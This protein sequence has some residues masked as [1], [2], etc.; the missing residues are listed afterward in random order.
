MIACLLPALLFQEQLFTDWSS[1]PIGEPLLFSERG[2]TCGY[3]RN[4]FGVLLSESGVKAKTVRLPEGASAAYFERSGNVVC[5]VWSPI[6]SYGS[7][8]NWRDPDGMAIRWVVR[9]K[10]CFARS[11][12]LVMISSGTSLRFGRY[13]SSNA[14]GVTLDGTRICYSKYED[15]QTFFDVYDRMGSEWISKKIQTVAVG[16]VGRVMILPR[17]ND[18]VFLDREHVAFL[19]VVPEPEN[20]EALATWEKGLPDLLRFPLD[21][22][23]SKSSCALMV[24]DLRTGQTTGIAKFGYADLGEPEGARTGTFTLSSTGRFLFLRARDRILRF[25]C[26]EMLKRV[27]KQ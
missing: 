18:V 16:K 8:G 25:N 21:F 20:N 2:E 27:L 5:V 14:V 1:C 13:T 19:G 11:D 23:K 22:F 12:D 9:E 3:S 7:S 6:R 17:F 10:T 15:G 4:G 24:S 26:E